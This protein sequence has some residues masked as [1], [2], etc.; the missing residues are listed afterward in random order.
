[1]KTCPNC[2]EEVEDSFELCWNC[3]YSFSENKVVEIEYASEVNTLKLKCLRCHTAMQFVGNSRFHEGTQ[4]GVLGNLFELFEN[5][6]S[7]DLYACPSC[8]KV[9]FF[10]PQK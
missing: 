10:M 4:F 7:F 9:E 2:N 6:Q 3:N 5:R 1:M 8:G